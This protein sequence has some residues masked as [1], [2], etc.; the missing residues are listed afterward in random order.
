M[1]GNVWEWVAD[2]YDSGYY[3][4]LADGVRDP[5]GPLSGEYRVLRGGSWS[6][7]E[8]RLRVSNRNWNSPDYNNFNFGFRCFR[9]P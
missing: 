3:G 9:S 4:S 5:I 2:W 8:D 7:Y 6:Y 1:A